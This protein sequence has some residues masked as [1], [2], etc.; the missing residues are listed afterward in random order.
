[1][2]GE[3]LGEV[4]FG[5][6]RDVAACVVDD[7][8]PRTKI[9][10]HRGVTEL[11]VEIEKHDGLS[12]GGEG[13]GDVGRERR[14]ADA[15]LTVNER[16]DHRELARRRDHLRHAPRLS[17]DRLDLRRQD[18]QVDRLADVVVG[19]V[20][21]ARQ[22]V[23]LLFGGGE[24]D[25]RRAGGAAILAE[26]FDELEA[27][28]QRHVHVG[29]DEVRRPLAFDESQGLDTVRDRLDAVPAFREVDG[30]EL[31]DRVVVVDAEDLLARHAFLSVFH[32]PLD[33]PQCA[34]AKD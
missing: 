26:A 3:V 32:P 1:M 24:D 16:D 21:V 31:A 9:E 29:D 23:L 15:A 17:Q 20:G 6:A 27:V 22:D 28:H 34:A 10:E 33:S 11:Q 2:V 7:R 8:R 12:L 30:A 5:D 14:R 25:D 4:L 19:A 18:R 13:G